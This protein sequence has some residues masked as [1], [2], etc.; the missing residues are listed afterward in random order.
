MRPAARA[1]DSIAALARGT[2][3][4]AATVG[5]PSKSSGSGTVQRN[6]QS[7]VRKARGCDVDG[8]IDARSETGLDYP[9]SQMA[10]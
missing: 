1:G 5:A 9:V 4:Q 10:R 6:G 3:M 2:P 8:R 7:S